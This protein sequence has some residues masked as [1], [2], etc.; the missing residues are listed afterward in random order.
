MSKKTAN[1]IV[2]LATDPNRISTREI[3]SGLTDNFIELHGDRYYGDD[4]AIIGGIGTIDS[5]P[6]TI[7]G[8]R[9]GQSLEENIKTNFG[10]PSPEGYRKALRLMKQAE[11]FK[12]PV[13]TLVNTPG[14]FCGVEAEERGEGE[15]IAN[16]LYEMSQ[17]KTPIL[18]I[19]TGEGG[20]GGALALAVAN[21]VWILEHSVYSIL[22]PRGFATILWKDSSLEAEAAEIMKL[23]PNDLLDL[24]VVDKIIAET[25]DLGNLTHEQIINNLKSEILM[26]LQA[27]SKM[28]TEDVIVQRYGRF[29]KF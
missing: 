21:D 25:D 24:K 15:A 6:V 20:S 23:T 14:A 8:V 12:R 7:I 29:R 9:K 17:L 4:E 5:H 22:S 1:D 16:N 27:Y 28:T 11:K 10:S 26:Q 2:K 18:S 19:M 13:I 3:I